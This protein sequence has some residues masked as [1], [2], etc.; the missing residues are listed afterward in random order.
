MGFRLGGVG[1]LELFGVAI[2]TCEAFEGVLQFH[3]FSIRLG[4]LVV[5]P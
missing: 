3:E 1:V 5:G 4:V 2:R